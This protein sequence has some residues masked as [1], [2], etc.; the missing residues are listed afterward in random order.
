[1]KPSKCDAK[2]SQAILREFAYEPEL[3]YE[4]VRQMAASWKSRQ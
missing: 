2:Q 3:Q 1:M 4:V